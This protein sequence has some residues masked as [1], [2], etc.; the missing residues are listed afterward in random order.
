MLQCCF[1]NK[2]VKKVMP[3]GIETLTTLCEFNRLITHSKWSFYCFVVNPS[4]LSTDDKAFSFSAASYSV[5]KSAKK[6]TVEVQLNHR[7]SRFV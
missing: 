5:V 7:I 2:F 1:R 4:F 3:F 6:L